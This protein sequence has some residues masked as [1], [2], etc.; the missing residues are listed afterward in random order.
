MRERP[1]GRSLFMS[2][3][4]CR[5]SVNRYSGACRRARLTMN[6]LLQKSLDDEHVYLRRCASQVYRQ[7]RIFSANCQSVGGLDA[8][9]MLRRFVP[10]TINNYSSVRKAVVGGA[11][12]KMSPPSFQFTVESRNG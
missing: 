9:Q 5:I 6:Y 7:R 2:N 8:V 12:W 1:A 4:V 11:V 3:S 10:W